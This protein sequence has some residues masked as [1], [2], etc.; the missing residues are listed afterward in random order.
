[1]QVRDTVGS[2]DAF[3]AGLLYKL[4]QGAPLDSACGFANKMGALISSKK[5]SIPDYDLA[6]LD[7]LV[8]VGPPCP[9]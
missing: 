3:S 2:G 5:S 8:D 9:F 7:A 1:V 4:A 6:E